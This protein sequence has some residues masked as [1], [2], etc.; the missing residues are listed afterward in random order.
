VVTPDRERESRKP[1]GEADGEDDERAND[2]KAHVNLHVSFDNRTRERFPKERR[3][4][5]ECVFC[6]ARKYARY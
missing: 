1:D 4:Y 2:D 5:C 6:A 3:G